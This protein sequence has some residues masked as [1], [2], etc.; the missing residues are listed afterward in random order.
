MEHLLHD[1]GGLIVLDPICNRSRLSDIPK[2]HKSLLPSW[3]ICP[4][5]A[6]GCSVA[7]EC[8]EGEEHQPS[9]VGEPPLVIVGGQGR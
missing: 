5:S 1:D 8:L 6:R 9:M 2:T 4:L 3:F 7:Y